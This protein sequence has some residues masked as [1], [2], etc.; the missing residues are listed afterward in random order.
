[1]TASCK[2]RPLSASSSLLD[3]LAFDE[4]AISVF[5]KLEVDEHAWKRRKGKDGERPK[6][7]QH[8]LFYTIHMFAILLLTFYI[9]LYVISYLGPHCWDY[10]FS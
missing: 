1:M 4:K 8:T 2:S 3:F 10:L 6:E 5:H 7:S 9:D